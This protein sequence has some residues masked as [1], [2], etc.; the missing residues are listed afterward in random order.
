[1]DE[2]KSLNEN[3]SINDITNEKSVNKQPTDV[4]EIINETESVDT[5]EAIEETEL[6]SSSTTEESQEIV[7][8]PEVVNNCLLYTSPLGSYHPKYKNLYYPVNYGYVENIIAGDN[9]WQD[10]YILSLIHIFI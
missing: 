10:V 2:K 3:E 5:Q 7:S 1:M 4:Q 8:E 6:T 9:E